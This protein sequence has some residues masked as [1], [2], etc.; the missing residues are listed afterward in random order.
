MRV[1][2]RLR[3]DAAG[4]CRPGWRLDGPGRSTGG[5]EAPRVRRVRVPTR[6]SHAHEAAP[7]RALRCLR[8]VRRGGRHGR[9]VRRRRPPGAELS[10]PGPGADL[11]G[12]LERRRR[13]LR[14]GDDIG[15]ERPDL[16]GRV[17]HH[18]LRGHRPVSRGLR[19]SPL[20]R[21]DPGA[22]ALVRPSGGSGPVPR[23]V[24]GPSLPCPARARRMVRRAR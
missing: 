1:L 10:R 23:P 20:T 11:H 21:V 15:D 22:D 14:P 6:A 19:R 3:V 16:T 24:H 17:R 18:L 2:A 9:T 8:P 13:A 5:R 12:T 7:R 4:R